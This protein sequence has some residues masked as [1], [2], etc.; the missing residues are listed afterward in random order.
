MRKF[1]LKYA[2]LH[3]SVFVPGFGDLSDTLPPITKSLSGVEFFADETGNVFLKYKEKYHSVVP[4]T[5]MKVVTFGEPVEEIASYALTYQ[6]TTKR[7]ASGAETAE[8]TK[9]VKDGDSK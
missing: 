7:V 4:S 8:L 6:S 5:N 1:K 3:A 2:K 9:R